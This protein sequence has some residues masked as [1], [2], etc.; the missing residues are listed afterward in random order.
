MITRQASEADPGAVIFQAGVLC[1]RHRQRRA[2]GNTMRA[3]GTSNIDGTTRP[4][5]T[6]WIQC[7]EEAARMDRA[8]ATTTTVP[9]RLFRVPTTTPSLCRTPSWGAAAFWNLGRVWA[10]TR[11][12]L[13]IAFGRAKHASQRRRPRLPHPNPL[14]WTR[15]CFTNCPDIS[16]S[17]LRHQRQFST[18]VASRVR[19]ARRQRRAEGEEGNHQRASRA[20]GTKRS[21]EARQ[22]SRSTSARWRVLKVKVAQVR[23]PHLVH[24]YRKLPRA[25]QRRQAPQ[26]RQTQNTMR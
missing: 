3:R 12:R 9:F 4:G 17:K 15:S 5:K 18:P 11:R 23:H 19:Q 7:T 22:P 8:S 26:F 24:C 13:R 21:V 2:D 25:R 6:G 1:L 10:S 14:R 20:R 16:R